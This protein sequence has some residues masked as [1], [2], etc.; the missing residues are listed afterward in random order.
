MAKLDGKVALLP[1]LLPDLEKEFLL[2]MQ[3][4]E[5]S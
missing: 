1:E 2:R 5:Q 3:N 4:T